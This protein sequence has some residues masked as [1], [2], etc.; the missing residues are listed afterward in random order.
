MK[1]PLCHKVIEIKKN[2]FGNSF[3]YFLGCFECEIGIYSYDL[4]KLESLL[5][6]WVIPD[7][8][9]KQARIDWHEKMIQNE[10]ENY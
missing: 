2:Y 1:C 8:E 7:C 5:S 9:N 10:C 3:E 4:K 6:F